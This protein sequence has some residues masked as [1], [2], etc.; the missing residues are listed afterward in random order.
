MRSIGG[1]KS[2]KKIVKITLVELNPIFVYL[3][4]CGVDSV[5]F[6]CQSI[7]KYSEYLG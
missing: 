6:I 5:S 1:D 4:L 2:E 7:E 3:S